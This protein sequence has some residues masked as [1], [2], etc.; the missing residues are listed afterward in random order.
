MKKLLT[1]LLSLSITA[2]SSVSAFC[3]APSVHVSCFEGKSE[4]VYSGGIK[5]TDSPAVLIYINGNYDGNA[6]PV[7][8]NG[9]T[10]VPLRVISEGLGA[11]VNWDGETKTVNIEKN[12]LDIACKTGNS[13]ITVGDEKIETT[14]PSE[15]IND[16]TYVP[17][18][19][20]SSA[21][22]AKV[23][24]FDDID[25]EI[26]LITVDEEENYTITEDEA[27]RIAETAYFYDFLPSVKDVIYQ[28]RGI[29]ATGADKTNISERFGL[30][31]YIGK[32]TKDMGH[33]WYVELF[34]DC[35]TG[36]LVDKTDGT[37]YPVHAFSI[38]R[39]SV[40]E[41]GDYS[42]WGWAYQ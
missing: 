33:Y 28:I 15:I 14:S 25:E 7:I 31:P 32:V 22:G 40:S 35:K 11:V 1:L 20:I 23:G 34:D 39:F 18:R 21:L 42:G 16:R 41:P 6:Q 29:D 27:V 37:L 5:N 10:L 9:T 36:A 26:K 24:Y 17:L 38:V 30:S 2:I 13:F 4:I 19:A 12:G 8:K 3:A